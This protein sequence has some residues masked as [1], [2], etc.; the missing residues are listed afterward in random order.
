M[1]QRIVHSGHD[2]RWLRRT[3]E[4]GEQYGSRLLYVRDLRLAITYAQGNTEKLREQYYVYVFGDQ[5]YVICDEHDIEYWF[6]GEWEHVVH[7]ADANSGQNKHVW[8][9]IHRGTVFCW[10]AFYVKIDDISRM[11]EAVGDDNACGI[12]EY[13]AC[14]DCLIEEAHPLPLHGGL[15]E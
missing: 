14:T 11:R 2:D 6:N 13:A 4:E 5:L 9:A 1:T 12:D 3:N 10:D 8:C 15:D 7:P